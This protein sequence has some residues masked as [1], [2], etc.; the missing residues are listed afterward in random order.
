MK[1]PIK[2][3]NGDLWYGCDDKLN[4]LTLALLTIVILIFAVACWKLVA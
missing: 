3:E 1:E 2:D 4:P